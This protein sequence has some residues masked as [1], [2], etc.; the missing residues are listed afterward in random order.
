MARDPAV[1]DRERFAFGARRRG[2][3]AADDLDA[4]GA[5]PAGHVTAAD[6]TRAD[7][8]VRAQ[9]RPGLSHLR[10]RDTGVDDRRRRGGACPGVAGVEAQS[11]LGVERRR[12]DLWSAFEPVASAQRAGCDSGRGVPDAAHRRGIARQEP[13]ESS[14]DRYWP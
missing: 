4:R 5:L 6:S 1:A 2:R 14:Y 7:R 11:D 10:V 8:I 3:T 9:P 13:A 12:L